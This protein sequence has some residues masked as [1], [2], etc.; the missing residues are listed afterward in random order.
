MP[1]FLKQ[2]VRAHMNRRL[3]HKAEIYSFSKMFFRQKQHLYTTAHTKIARTAGRV[4][5][6]AK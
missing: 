5:Y 3:I 2:I 4:K 6:S 1:V